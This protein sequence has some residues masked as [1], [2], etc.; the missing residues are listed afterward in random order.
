[1]NYTTEMQV[2]LFMQSSLQI[3]QSFCLFNASQQQEFDAIRPSHI[4]IS[5]E[6]IENDAV[7]SV[8]FQEL[9]LATYQ[10]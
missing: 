9:L 4:F 2:N 1:M 3:N 6:T 5:V 7:K 10:F 8:R